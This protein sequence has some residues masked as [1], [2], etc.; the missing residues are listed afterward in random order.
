MVHIFI[1]I[2]IYGYVRA[3]GGA[4]GASR[5]VFRIRT[6]RK[7]AHQTKYPSKQVTPPKQTNISNQANKQT[8]KQTNKPVLSH[9]FEMDQFDL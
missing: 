6:I 5:I 2:Y 9:I 1:Y 8:N 4:A 3:A 7:Q